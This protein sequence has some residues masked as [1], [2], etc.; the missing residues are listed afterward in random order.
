MFQ[1]LNDKQLCAL[2]FSSIS[3]RLI[4]NLYQFETWFVNWVFL[5]IC[6]GKITTSNWGRDGSWHIEV[7]GKFIHTNL[8]PK[9]ED[10]RFT[11][12]IRPLKV[13]SER[14]WRARRG[15]HTK[16]AVVSPKYTLIFKSS[17]I[18]V[19]SIDQPKQLISG[20]DNAVRITAVWA[21][22]NSSYMSYL[23]VS[24]VNFRW[25]P[26]RQTPPKISVSTAN[27]TTHIKSF[28]KRE[29]IWWNGNQ[30]GN[31]PF[32]KALTEGGSRGMGRTTRSSSCGF[33]INSCGFKYKHCQS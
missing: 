1:D 27:R 28:S 31:S 7:W 30:F 26:I 20:V 9:A 6:V 24:K 32:S 19:I 10:G 11:V 18:I 8:R 12:R 13:V 2:L 23:R 17:L 4:T 14:G 33:M 16:R 15:C 25:E 3:Y 5:W 22:V 29:P 21:G